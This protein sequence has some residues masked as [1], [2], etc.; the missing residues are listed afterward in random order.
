MG[1]KKAKD[2]KLKGHHNGLLLVRLLAPSASAEIPE[3]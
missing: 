3:G 2:P 1:R